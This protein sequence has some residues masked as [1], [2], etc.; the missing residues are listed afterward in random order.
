[1]W[2]ITDNTDGRIRVALREHWSSLI[3]DDVLGCSHGYG[4]AVEIAHELTYLGF[5]RHKDFDL[6]PA[7]SAVLP[8]V[9]CS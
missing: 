3:A 7:G 1:M 5:E 2:R 9:M 8:L 6:R 4:V